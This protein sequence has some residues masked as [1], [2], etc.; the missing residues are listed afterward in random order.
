MRLDDLQVQSL[1]MKELDR[2]R[3]GVELIASENFAEFTELSG[4][5]VHG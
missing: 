2:Q 1:M 5:W 4:R 3:R